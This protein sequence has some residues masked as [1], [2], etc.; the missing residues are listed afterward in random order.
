MA[1]FGVGNLEPSVEDRVQRRAKRNG[2]SR[3]EEVARFSDRPGMGPGNLR[4]AYAPG[5]Q[6]CLPGKKGL[7]RSGELD[8][9]PGPTDHRMAAFDK[10]AGRQ[11]AKPNSRQASQ[12]PGSR[13]ARYDEGR[14]CFGASCPPCDSQ[15][16][17]LQ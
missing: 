10:E 13:L 7:V 9:L 3:E 6:P 12:R 16:L 8:R 11:A 15:R 1:R 5:A 2:R 14:N 4:T 17:T